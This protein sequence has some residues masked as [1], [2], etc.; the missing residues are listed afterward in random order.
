MKNQLLA[1]AEQTIE[2]GVPPDQQEAYQRILIAGMKVL[3]SQQTHGALVQGLEQSQDPIGDVGKGAVGLIMTLFKESKGTM[4]AK[5]MIPA[6]MALLLNALDYVDSTGIA[7]IG[8]PELDHATEVFINTLMPKVGLTP[9]RM[10]GLMGQIQGV[11]A[12]P[13]KMKQ[14]QQ[15]QG[16]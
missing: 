2:K 1:Q 6:G 7:K 16:A 13:E 10:Q 4:P 14:M 11:M 3:F 8:K 12:D 15:Q 5:A 9:D